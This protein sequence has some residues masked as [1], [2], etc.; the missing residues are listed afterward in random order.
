MSLVFILI[1]R[2]LMKPALS[3]KHKR[4]FFTVVFDAQF[5]LTVMRLYLGIMHHLLR[6]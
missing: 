3:R 1:L 4:V 6:T 5:E 2:V